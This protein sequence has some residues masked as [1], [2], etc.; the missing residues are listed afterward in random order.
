MRQTTNNALTLC[1]LVTYLFLTA[2]FAG[3]GGSS[4]GLL[5]DPA[6]IVE[7]EEFIL[8]WQEDVFFDKVFYQDLCENPREGDDPFNGNRPYSDQQGSTE[9]ENFYLRS[10]TNETYLWYDEVE[11]QDPGLFSTADYFAQLKTFER[12]PSNNFKDNFHFTQDTEDYLTTTVSG[13]TFGYGMNLVYRATVP[14]RD[15]IVRDVVPGSP[16]DLAGVE[17]GMSILEV[18]GVDMINGNDVDTLN[19]GLGPDVIGESHDFVFDPVDGL[20]N[21]EVTMASARISIAPVTEAQVID[22]ATGGVGYLHF[23]THIENATAGLIDAFELMVA[24]GASDL[25]LDM[26]YNGGGLL[27][28]AGQVGYMVAG[29]AQ[30][31]GRVFY[32]LDF[33]NKIG[34]GTTIGFNSSS[35]NFG[36]LTGNE[37]LPSLNLNR[38]FILASANTC[39]A[40]EAI[41]NGLRGID[42]EVVLIGSGTCGKP[43]GFIPEGN[44]GTTYFTV[45]FAGVNDD[46]FGEYPDGFAPANDP[47]LEGVSVPGCYVEDDY[48]RGLGDPTEAMLAAA[49]QYRV[50]ETCPG[51]A[52]PKPAPAFEKITQDAGAISKPVSPA[53]QNAI[54]R[55]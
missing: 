13:E 4:D 11:D 10:W 48:T 36:D 43:Y 35:L 55:P 41:I 49:L 51:V 52:I 33:N 46:G 12:T 16:A 8:T 19:G 37:P 2:A 54:L 23:S 45:Q 40:S 47:N 3:C 50:D 29:A 30:S 34:S 26:R 14:P 28:I 44:C 39:S 22:T 21:L 42:V 20:A 15:V 6:N 17:R 38:V 32:R 31:S 24:E 5:S 1:R 7:D 18:D 9:Y 27:D 25:V 53:Q